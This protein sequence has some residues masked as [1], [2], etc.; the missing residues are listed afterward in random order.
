MTISEYQEKI[1]NLNLKLDYEK[2]TY[3]YITPNQDDI[4]G[5][6]DAIYNSG[7]LNSNTID[8]KICDIGFGLGLSMFNLNLQFNKN[9]IR[10]NTSFIGVENDENLISIFNSTFKKYWN[11]ISIS[12]SDAMDHDYSKYDIIYTYL[13]YKDDVKMIDLYNKIFDDMKIGSVIFEYWN[14]GINLYKIK[15]KDIKPI[16]LYF[17]NSKNLLFRKIS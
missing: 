9:Y 14:N 17:G 10:T 2:D 12:N 5:F 1:S 13:I 8:C 6:V 16:E 4:S 11:N 7:I 3:P 15:R